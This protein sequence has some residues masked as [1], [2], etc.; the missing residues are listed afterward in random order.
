MNT[1][2][3]LKIMT[4]RKR[5][6][7]IVFNTPAGEAVLIDLTPYCREKETCVAA[8][9]SKAPIDI[10]RTFLLEGRRDVLLRIR[11]HLELTP[12]Q[13]VER[14]TVRIETEE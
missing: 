12:E 13:L 9:N 11:E 6:Y 5:A 10:Y 14:Y 2:D 3:A 4:D 7:Q 1:D 8:Q